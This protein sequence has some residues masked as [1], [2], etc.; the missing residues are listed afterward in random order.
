M[1]RKLSGRR[2]SEVYR[3]CPCSLSVSEAAWATTLS[4]IAPGTAAGDAQA[5]RRSSQRWPIVEEEGD[6]N[7]EFSFCNQQESRPAG[8]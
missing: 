1:S 4:S 8:L 7:E 5:K 3:E 2:G 6:Q